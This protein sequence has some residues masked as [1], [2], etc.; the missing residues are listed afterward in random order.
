MVWCMLLGVGLVNVGL[1]NFFIWIFGS[2]FFMSFFKV[3]KNILFCGLWIFIKFIM[4]EIVLV[5]GVIWCLIGIC[6][7]VGLRIVVI[8]LFFFVWLYFDRDWWK[9]KFYGW[10]LVK[11]WFFVIWRLNWF[12]LLFNY[13][14]CWKIYWCLNL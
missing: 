7:F 3:F 2:C 1:K 14:R 6:L 13:E 4:L 9:G 12:F 5:C 8:K 11:F 10:Y